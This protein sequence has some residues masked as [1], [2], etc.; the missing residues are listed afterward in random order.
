MIKKVTNSNNNNNNNNKDKKKCKI[1][2]TVIKKYSKNEC[3]T[4]H[5]IYVHFSSH[6]SPSFALYTAFSAYTFLKPKKTMRTAPTKAT[7]YPLPKVTSTYKC[8]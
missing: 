6:F 8:I 4:D 5:P 7:I 3:F 1:V 2:I